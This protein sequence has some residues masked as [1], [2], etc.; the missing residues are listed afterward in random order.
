MD[1]LLDITS[2]INYQTFG[3]YIC[4]TTLSLT[5][6]L[7]FPDIAIRNRDLPSSDWKT[8]VVD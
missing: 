8:S 1:G 4:T 6:S 2:L 3:P 5:P 7:Y